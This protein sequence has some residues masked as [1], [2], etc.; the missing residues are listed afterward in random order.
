MKFL[1]PSLSVEPIDQKLMHW[2]ADNHYPL[3]CAGV[4]VR[5][6]YDQMRLSFNKPYEGTDIFHAVYE[7]GNVNAVCLKALPLKVE[8]TY[9]P[10]IEQLTAQPRLELTQYKNLISEFNLTCDDCYGFFGPT[11]FP[12]DIKHI[13]IIT[14]KKFSAKELYEKVLNTN[15]SNSW[16]S[17]A[18]FTIFILTRDPFI[19]DEMKKKVCCETGM[20]LVE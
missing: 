13:D 20:H 16:Q 2:H 12:I 18:G 11:I 1:D 14:K 8:K 4:F 9:T 6:K 17:Y 10:L 7:N 5:S 15:N 3:V 19:K